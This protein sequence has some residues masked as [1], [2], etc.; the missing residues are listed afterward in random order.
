MK[1]RDFLITSAGVTAGSVLSPLAFGAKPCPPSTLS[2]E[3]GT[4]VSTTCAAAGDAEADW[5]LRTGQ[6]SASPQPGVVWFHDFRSDAEVNAFRWTPGYSGGNDPRAVGS[7]TAALARRVAGGG[8]G[9]GDCLELLRRAGTSEGSQWWRPFSPMVGTGNG[10]GANDPAANGSLTPQAYAATDGGSQVYEWGRRGYYGHSSYHTGSQFD[11]TEYYLQMRIKMDPRRTTAGNSLVGKLTF[12][13]TT[14]WSLTVQEIVT[15]S[16]SKVGS[17]GMPNY[18]R[19]YGGGNSNPLEDKN[20]GP[21]NTQPGS[22]LGVC[23]ISSPSK[24]W[25]WS[26]GWDTIMYHLTPGRAGVAESRMQVYAA[27]EGQTSYTKIWDEVWSNFYENGGELTANGYNA[28]ILATYQNGLN[29]SEFWHRYTQ[30]IF[31]KQFIP[32]PQV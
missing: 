24:C 26:G 6:N 12:H 30:I 31:S 4:A 10:R 27:H 2:V 15:Y 9:G 14:R 28:L 16:A 3:G 29:N 13:T 23:D 32:C 17:V 1:R 19:M 25:A 22:E 11:G 7:S 18:F 21:N 20:V 5:L 8:I